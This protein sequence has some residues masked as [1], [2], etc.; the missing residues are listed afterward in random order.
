M[1]CDVAM[2]RRE[3][4]PRRVAAQRELG[5]HGA[6]R[7]IS[8]G[9][10]PPSE[11]SCAE[12]VPITTKS[13]VAQAGAG[14]APSWCS[15]S[16]IAWVY[17]G[18]YLRPN[19]GALRVFIPAGM[20][21]ARQRGVGRKEAHPLGRNDLGQSAV[22][23]FIAD[24][25]ASPLRVV[26]HLAPSHCVI[27]QDMSETLHCAGAHASAPA[28]FA[29]RRRTAHGGCSMS[30]VHMTP[31]MERALLAVGGETTHNAP[32]CERQG[33]KTRAGSGPAPCMPHAQAKPGGRHACPGSGAT[34]THSG[35]YVSSGMGRRP[36][37]S[38]GHERR[39]V[40]A[41]PADTT[42]GTLRVR[43]GTACRR[44]EARH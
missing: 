15:V 16:L 10:R 33:T 6:A 34:T 36:R 1:A 35:H 24:A 29:G 22:L 40:A 5:T 30:R 32:L 28:W 26:V 8:G 3:P 25:S 41:R 17:D 9:S 18:A 19:Q 2:G 20:D 7:R 21:R 23:P 42:V 37:R 43:S 38:L 4:R 12:P 13:V 27:D 14:D 11:R 44:V 39:R 31:H